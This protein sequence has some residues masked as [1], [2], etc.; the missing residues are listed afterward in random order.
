MPHRAVRRRLAALAPPAALLLAGAI[1]VAACSGTTSG[2]TLSPPASG[3]SPAAAEPVTL[4]L[5]VSLTPE[6]LAAFRPALETLSAAHPEW[7]VR[8]E[9]VPQGSE[10]EKVTADL[11]AGTLPD[12]LRVQG[13][14]VQQ[15]IRRSAFLDLDE[16]IVADLDGADDFYPGPL[17][18]FTW[19][20]RAWGLPDTASPEVVFYNT[21]MFDAAGLAYPTRAWT[22]DDMRAAAIALTLDAGGR[23][24][25]EE[26]FDPARIRQW[27]W[28]GGLTYFWQ[29]EM[30][31]AL[32]GDLCLNA[33]CT[34]MSFTDPAT[35][36]AIEWWVTL[37][38]DDHA[39]PYDPYGGSQTGVPGDPFLAGA[40][41]MGSNG[42][43]A[44][45]QLNAAATIAY[46]VAPPLVGVDGQRHTPLST[47]GYVIA[48]SSDHP[49]EAWALVQALVAPEFLASTWG[50]PGHAVPARISVAG[51]VIDAGHGPANQGAVLE[52]MAA[53]RVFRPYTASAFAAYGATVDLFT[54]LNTG[55]LAI[56]DGLARLEAAANEALAP[57]RDP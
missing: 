13:L 6:E 20:D 42:W 30:V 43:F 5:Q 46:D 1:G 37:V 10:V 9:A 29:N 57:D 32:G 16:R 21:A 31:R 7:V 27:G 52:A 4:R 56:E 39:A 11:A 36:A 34:S 44:V 48:A 17:E 26:G 54:R 22:Y 33:D 24:P 12:V 41:A 19:Q 51:S 45:G 49:D 28:N 47:N 50:R 3:A 15:W 23:H 55:E 14:N 18:Q 25:G 38:R 40:A 2:P 8:L 35:A 53:G